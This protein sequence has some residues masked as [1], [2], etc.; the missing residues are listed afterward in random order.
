[1]E[2][3]VHDGPNKKPLESIY[4]SFTF[5]EPRVARPGFIHPDELQ[6][7]A[8]HA[9]TRIELLKV[10][11]FPLALSATIPNYVVAG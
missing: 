11:D 1:M 6:A 5:K 7:N 9:Q 4:G 10:Y 8:S 3:W 2:F